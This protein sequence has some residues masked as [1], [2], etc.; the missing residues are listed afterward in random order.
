MR[1][2][3]YQ[4]TS[5]LEETNSDLQYPKQALIRDAN[6]MHILK[7]PTLH[8]RQTDRLWGLCNVLNDS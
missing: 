5:D 3:S 1:G 7:G 8:L 2:C 4:G 6:L